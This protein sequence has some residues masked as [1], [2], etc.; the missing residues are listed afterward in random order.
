MQAST[1]VQG[2]MCS[3]QRPSG[4]VLC[5]KPHNASRTKRTCT[6]S[7]MSYTTITTPKTNGKTSSTT[8]MLL[9]ACSS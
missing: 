7:M 3:E 2:H 5:G 9:K 8:I 6:G 1:R 4:S